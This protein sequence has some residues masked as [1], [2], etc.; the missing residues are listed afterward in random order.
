MRHSIIL[1]LISLM[2]AVCA[3]AQPGGFGGRGPMGPPP[4]GGRPYNQTGTP[5]FNNSADDSKAT[6]VKKK[7]RVTDGSTFKVV[8]SLRDST[9][10]E[11]LPFVN[12][13]VLDSVD[14]TF[15]KGAATNGDGYF[16]VSEIPAGGFLL[17]VSAIGYQNVFIPFHVSNNTA[18]GTIRL[19]QGATTLNEVVVTAAKPLYAMDGEKT[20]YNVSD[21]PSIQTGTTNDALQNAPG[22]EVDVEGNITLRGVT[23]VEIW[24]NDKPSKLTEENLKTYLETLPANALARIETITNPSAKYATDAEAVINIVTSAHIKSNHF[25]S[26]G[27]F[28]SSQPSIGPWLSYMW[29][30]ERLSINIHAGGRYNYSETNSHSSAISRKYGTT[31]DYDTTSMATNDSESESKRLS[32][33]IGA[34]ID[35][36]ID[37]MTDL[38]VHGMFNINRNKAISSSHEWYDQHFIVDNPYTYNL[39]DTTDNDNKGR[40]GMFGANIT[41]KFDNKGH[42]LRVTF[43]GNFNN[44]NVDNYMTRI[45]DNVFGDEYKYYENTTSKQSYSLNARY[46][47]PYGEQ[48]EMSYGL[49]A[50]RS[51]SHNIYSRLYDTLPDRY[52]MNDILRAYEFKG[53]D[54]RINADV[55]WTH[56]WGGFT[57]ELGLGGR[58]DN[59]YFNYISEMKGFSDEQTF[60]FFTLNPSIHTSYRTEDMHNFKLNYSMRMSNPTEAQLTSFKKYSETAYSTG[61]SS[62]KS[63]TTHSMEAGWT[64]FFESF[65]SVG[66]EGYGRYSV[67]EISSLTESSDEEDFYLQRIINYS[68]PYNMGSSYRLGGTIHMTYRP[69]GFINI[70]L[71][72]NIYDYGYRMERPNGTVLENSK[73]S[74]SIRLNIWAKVFNKYQ[75]YISGGYTSPTIALASER[76]ENYNINF[77]VRADFFK[78]KMTAFINIQDIFNW[79][80][81]I[82]SGSKNTNPLYITDVTSKTVNSRFISAGLTFRFGKME[83]ERKAEGIESDT[84]SSTSE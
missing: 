49:G 44:G 48:G 47:R 41:H 68:T 64:K 33:N 83:L 18:L 62:L 43:D 73:L 72:S 23:S 74:Y 82:G 57:L 52:S 8:G 34:H 42:N 22:V 58:Y 20:I 45:Y 6:T 1:L 66:I 5:R 65:G 67:N 36:A 29:A 4:G 76:K 54:S 46:N 32:G 27:L 13:S 37:S 11:F 28:G 3:I 7:K 56:R 15:V 80:K 69:S 9:T 77:G 59:I 81:N 19:K 70:R 25:I 39:F 50:S 63:S 51:N 38:N 35:Y 10:G 55:N 40:F 21:D 53:N 75:F 84:S 17:R 60:N 30:N 12:V 24:I 71:Y 61:N 31:Q 16:E 79:G 2:F 26:F 78:R 14:S